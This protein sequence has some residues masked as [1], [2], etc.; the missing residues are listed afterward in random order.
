MILANRPIFLIAAG[1]TLIGVDDEPES[2][3]TAF[4]EREDAD[5]YRTWCAARKD[6]PVQ[7]Y[8]VIEY[9]PKTWAS[10]DASG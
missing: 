7:V 1:D 4:I 9:V 5:A 8:R 6:V 3:I 10:A 2:G